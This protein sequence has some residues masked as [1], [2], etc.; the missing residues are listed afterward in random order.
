M[1]NL[2]KYQETMIIQ[3]KNIRLLISTK[4]Y[5]AIGIDLSR[6]TNMTIHQ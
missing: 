6:Q 4:L 2:W 5:E 3:R 1:K